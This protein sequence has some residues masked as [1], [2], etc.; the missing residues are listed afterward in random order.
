VSHHRTAGLLLTAVILGLGACSSDSDDSGSE[1]TSPE[2]DDVADAGSPEPED[3]SDDVDDEGGDDIRFGSLDELVVAFDLS[4]CE[5]AEGVVLQL[6]T[7]PDES[8]ACGD[9]VEVD[10]YEDPATFEEAQAE[11]EDQICSEVDGEWSYLVGDGW[12]L[13]AEF[14]AEPG[15]DDAALEILAR[16]GGTGTIEAF[17]C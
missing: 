5:P 6:T 4:G 10:W 8:L 1:D 16:R 17:S 7:R 15:S 12:T 9:T 11:T 14:P 2:V 13:T 3:V